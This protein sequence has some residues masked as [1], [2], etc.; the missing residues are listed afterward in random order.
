MLL[1]LVEAVVNM[2]WSPCN[3]KVVGSTPTTGSI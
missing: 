2:E 1:L 3:W